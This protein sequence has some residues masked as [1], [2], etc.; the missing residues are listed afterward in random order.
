[1]TA[2]D[3]ILEIESLPQ[4]ERAKVE[5]W[6]RTRDLAREDAIDL[7]TLEERKKEPS[8]DL[9]VALSDLGIKPE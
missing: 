5:A 9:R 8:R 6:L 7:A 1:M 3:L 4:D 2:R